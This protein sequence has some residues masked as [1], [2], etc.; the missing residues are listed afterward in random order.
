MLLYIKY[1]LKWVIVSMNTVLASKSPRRKELLGLLDLDFE[2]ITAD[3][4]ET[5]DP[6][7]SVNEEVA[8]LSYEKASAI[9]AKVSPDTVI[10]SADTVVELNGRVMG[11]PKNEQDAFDMLKNLSGNNHNVLTG[12]TVIQ[13][14]KHITKVV[15]TKVYFRNI[16]DDEILSYIETLEPMDKAGAYGIQGRA[17]KF[18]QKIDGDYF[19]VV[20]LPVCELS[21]ILKEFGIN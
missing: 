2:I 13:G 5:M 12:V 17:S 7:L 8:R 21:L 15:T 9:K 1:I 20:G 3:I 19:N 14:D 11:K 10:I 6:A 4:D 16:T 18:V